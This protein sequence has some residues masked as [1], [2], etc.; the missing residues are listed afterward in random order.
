[1]SADIIQAQYDQLEA[2]ARRFGK[3][4]D[5]QAALQKRVRTTS[6]RLRTAW[7]GR[8]SEAFYAEMDGKVFP[9][10]QRLIE[11]L[12]EAQKV[13]LEI[14]E[15]VRQAEGD[16][17]KPFQQQ[18]PLPGSTPPQGP[19]DP[20]EPRPALPQEG[21]SAVADLAARLGVPPS[22]ISVRSVEAV[23]WNDASLGWAQPGYLYAQIVI[24]GYRIVLE[25]AGKSYEYHTGGS[26]FVLCI[27]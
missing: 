17:A 20:A 8:G 16:A 15:I 13:T 24:P 2:L 19:A 18:D 21:E 26:H 5:L 27:R 14:N 9:A 12:R 22:A 23:Q 3:Q 6:T 7:V 11:A 10:M 25:V 1:M 4:A